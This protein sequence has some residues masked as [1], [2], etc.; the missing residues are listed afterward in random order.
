M[1]FL[2]DNIILAFN[3]QILVNFFQQKQSEIFIEKFSKNYCLIGVYL[4]L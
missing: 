4:L 3:P 2:V 1:S